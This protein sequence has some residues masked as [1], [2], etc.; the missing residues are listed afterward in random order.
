MS[1]IFP[2]STGTQCYELN[3]VL[4]KFLCWS[5]NS[6]MIVFGNYFWE[7]VKVKKKWG[8]SWIGLVALQ[9]VGEKISFS[10]AC[11]K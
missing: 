5:P 4:S 8:P 10:T 11:S 6:N 1:F 3:C 2:S 7:V 9:V